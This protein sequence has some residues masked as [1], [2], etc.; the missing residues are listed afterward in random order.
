MKIILKKDI[1]DLKEQGDG[2]RNSIFN[3]KIEYKDCENKLI[4]TE[5]K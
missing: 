1:N 2:L 5:Q 3:L 4:Q